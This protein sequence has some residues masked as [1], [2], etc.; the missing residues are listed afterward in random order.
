MKMKKN[1]TC[2]FVLFIILSCE[3]KNK[4]NKIILEKNKPVLIEKKINCDSISK[5]WSLLQSKKNSIIDNIINQNKSSLSK[6]NLNLLVSLKEKND[7][8]LK[9][10]QPLSA[11]FKGLAPEPFI[12]SNVQWKK[13]GEGFVNYFPENYLLKKVDTNEGN[14]FIDNSRK[15]FKNILK[16]INQKEREVFVLGFSKTSKAIVSVFG[17]QNSECEPY[18]FY[19][20]D[21][22]NKN[23]VTTPLV[24]SQYDISVEFG[25]W[26][27]I[28][29]LIKNGPFSKC[30]DCVNS[31]TKSK[32]FARLKGTKNVYFSFNGPTKK[33]ED[34]YTPDRSLIYIT[35][36]KEIIYLWSDAIDLFGCSCL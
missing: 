27:N 17:K 5:A 33:L 20:L 31:Y 2:L 23:L 13:K 11:I 9:F 6:E 4:K 26:S 32:T 14:N 18:V 16:E 12:I 21:F 19:N 24:V 22:N 28:D 30:S 36:N 1:I 3:I 10:K 34:S 7:S 15:Y 29:L 25:N 35:E 8:I